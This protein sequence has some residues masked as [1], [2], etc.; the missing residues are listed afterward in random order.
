MAMLRVGTETENM[1]TPRPYGGGK[2]IQ[3]CWHPRQ[4]SLVSHLDEHGRRAIL[5]GIGDVED[6]GKLIGRAVLG[7]L[8]DDDAS[9]KADNDAAKERPRNAAVEEDA[10]ADRREDGRDGGC[11]P[12]ALAD[13]REERLEGRVVV[14]LGVADVGDADERCDD[15]EAVEPQRQRDARRHD[16]V[17]VPDLVI[18]REGRVHAGHGELGRERGRRDDGA[19]IGLE[20]VGAHARDVADVIADVVCMPRAAGRGSD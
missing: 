2:G 13:D 15:A 18:E 16:H 7:E 3:V 14:E 9:D 1:P 12:D 5:G 20:E 11:D 8:G 17:E 4:L 6:R 10:D 19:C